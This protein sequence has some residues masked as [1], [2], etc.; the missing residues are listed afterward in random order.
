MADERDRRIAEL[1]A[2]VDELERMNAN[3]YRMHRE[4][5][6]KDRNIKP[7]KEHCGY[8][9]F[10]SQQRK[11]SIDKR[12]YCVIWETRIQTPY[13]LQ[14]TYL[15]MWEAFKQDLKRELKDALMIDGFC[16]NAENALD[17]MTPDTRNIVFGDILV[18][19]NY[20]SGY[21]EILI[22]STEELRLAK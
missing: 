20:G 1:E 3:L 16:S 11:E 22:K 8:V 21:W 18:S 19:A 7:H 17:S 14:M 9:L 4:Q 5:S 2:R 6:N 13:K 10:V 15:E 12:T